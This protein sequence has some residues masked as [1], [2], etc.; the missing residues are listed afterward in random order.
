MLL[1]AALA[2]QDRYEEGLASLQ[3]A[4]KRDGTLL[5]GWNFLSICYRNLGRLADAEAACLSALKVRPDDGANFNLGIVYMMSGQFDKAANCFVTALQAHPNNPQIL[6]HLGEAMEGLGEDDKALDCFRKSAKLAPGAVEPLLSLGT[7]SLRRGDAEEALTCASAALAIAPDSTV[8]LGLASRANLGLNR[9]EEADAQINRLLE[10]DP[11]NAMAFAVQGIQRQYQGDFSGAAKSFQES[12]EL[13]PIQGIGYWGILQGKKCGPDDREI[14]PKLAQLASDQRIEPFER[15]YLSYAAGKVEDDCGDFAAAIRHYD[16]AAKLA[17]ASSAVARKFDR[18]AYRREFETLK[19]LFNAELR[20]ASAQLADLS[21]RPIFVVGMIRS[22]TTLMEQILSSHPDVVGAGETRYWINRG[23]SCVDLAARR[24]DASRSKAL[25]DTYLGML[26]KLDG[27]APH[28]TDK[29][30][31]NLRLVGLIN[32]LL[33]N[34]KIVTMRRNAVDNCLSIYA[35]PYAFPPEYAFVRDHIALAYDEHRKLADYW[36]ESLPTGAITTV[37]YEDL[38]DDPEAT[39]RSV[40]D[41]C[42]LPWNDAVLRHQEN[43]R[44][45]LTPSLWQARQPI[46]RSSRDRGKNYAGLLP[47]FERLSS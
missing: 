19:G 11:G 23:Y 14:L 32:I 40:L 46:Y 35:T 4:V 9:I 39:I 15:A 38:I 20:A 29:T 6:H 41:H 26:E 43:R 10:L 2:K 28:V 34:A 42:G 16:D 1:G 47:E 17:A 36:Q 8:V 44:T 24:I 12:I 3:V 37:R 31:E 7:L 30:P 27:E 13:N 33:P 21:A 5:E 25:V 45:V 18:D 22:G